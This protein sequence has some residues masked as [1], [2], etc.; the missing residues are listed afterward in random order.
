MCFQRIAWNVD[1]RFY[2]GDAVIDD[3]SHRHLPQ[4]HPDHFTETHW[5]VRNPGANPE[6]EEI[7]END[8]Q[9]KR[10]EGE[11]ADADKINGLHVCRLTRRGERGKSIR[12]VGTHG[13]DAALRRPKHA[14]CRGGRRGALP[15]CA[16]SLQSGR[17][18]IRIAR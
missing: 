15:T 2:R 10:E 7:E 14:T 4:P 6:P 16:I 5:R 1:A 17:D 13:R 11:H 3:H 12:M 18:G 8:A 9:D